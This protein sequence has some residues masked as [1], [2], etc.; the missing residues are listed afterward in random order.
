[1][2]LRCPSSP[3]ERRADQVT[4]LLKGAFSFEQLVRF[5]HPFGD[6]RGPSPHKC[7][8]ATAIKAAHNGRVRRSLVV[9]GSAATILILGLVALFAVGGSGNASST[10]AL[11][12]LTTTTTTPT[13][14]TQTTIV[15]LIGPA[16]GPKRTTLAIVTVPDVV[17][18]TLTQAEPA[19][20]AVGLAAGSATPSIKTGGQSTTGTILAQSPAA[21][22]KLPQGSFVQLTISGY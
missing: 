18:M 14:T 4:G 10:G 11:P 7:V 5:G 16:P 22:S 3:P 9:L 6:P 21:G 19:L 17:G 2:A 8:L 1:M 15:N 12:V 20:A 13:P